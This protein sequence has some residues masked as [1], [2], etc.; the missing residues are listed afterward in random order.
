MTMPTRR[1]GADGPAIG[2]IGLGCM[3]MSEFYGATDE[4]ESLATLARALELGVDHIDTADIYG[5]GANEELVGKFAR[6]RR[7]KLVIATKFGIVRKQ[8]SYDRRIDNTP[9]YMRT[10]LDESLQ[11]LGTDYV[12]LYYIHRRDDA[13]QIEEIIAALGDEIRKGRIRAIGLSEVSPA[14]LKR[15]QAVHPIAAVQS[16]LSLWSREPLAEMLPLCA[17]TGTSF[18]PYSPLGRGFLTGAIVSADSLGANDFRRANPRFQGENLERNQAIVDATR[19]IA[20]AKTCTPAQ[21][22]LAWVLA[23]GPHVLP[24]PG[25]KRRKYLEENAAAAQ[26]VLTPDEVAALE[27]NLPPAAG[28]RYTQE[29]FKGID[30]EA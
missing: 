12:D 20:A 17:A 30:S 15:A 11:R 27:A 28:D 2:A 16:E 25:T 1:L 4:A 24:I 26:I 9:A 22:A 29:G 23:K 5:F 19:K 6:G 14:T 21:L 7:G 3:G 18:V 13:T 10:A 8:N